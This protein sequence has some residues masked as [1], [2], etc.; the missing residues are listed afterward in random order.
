MKICPVQKTWKIAGVTG[1]PLLC[2]EV[3]FLRDAP[4]EEWSDSLLK[5]DVLTCDLIR[6]KAADGEKRIGSD[7]R[8]QR[9]Q[10][11]SASSGLGEKKKT[12]IVHSGAH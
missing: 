4:R 9:I 11:H 8:H 2:A 12:L 6:E 10:F 3:V 7:K 5:T 1:R